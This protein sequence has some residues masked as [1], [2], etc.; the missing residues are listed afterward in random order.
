MYSK[1]MK[2][3]FVWRMDNMWR[4]H[5]VPSIAGAGTGSYLGQLLAIYLVIRMWRPF[6]SFF[7]R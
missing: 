1:L 3:M 5:L 4:D 6:F 7:F 2:T